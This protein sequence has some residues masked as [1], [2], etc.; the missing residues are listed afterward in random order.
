MIDYVDTNA[1][2]VR[3]PGRTTPADRVAFGGPEGD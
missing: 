1:A 3:R 2:R